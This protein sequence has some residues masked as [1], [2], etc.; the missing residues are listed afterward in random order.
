M[1]LL[2]LKIKSC[3]SIKQNQN[4]TGAARLLVVAIPKQTNTSNIANSKSDLAPGNITTVRLADII[5]TTP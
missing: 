3:A 1:T 5:N 4:K 2:R